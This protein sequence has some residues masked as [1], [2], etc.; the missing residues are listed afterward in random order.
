MSGTRR[1]Q[2]GRPL[3]VITDGLPILAINGRPTA[4]SSLNQ[5][6]AR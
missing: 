3:K 6:A 2:S 4:I 1:E 5:D